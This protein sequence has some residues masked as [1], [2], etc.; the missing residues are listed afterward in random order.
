MR[1]AASLGLRLEPE[2]AQSIKEAAPAIGRVTPERVRDEFLA[3]WPG[4]EC[5]ANWKFWTGWTCCAA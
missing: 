3:I 1:L 4:T 5:G 2:T